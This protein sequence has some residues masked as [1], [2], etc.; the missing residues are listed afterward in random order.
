MTHKFN[1]KVYQGKVRVY[2]AVP[3]APRIS[4][5]WIWDEAAKEYKVPEQGNVYY[6]ARYE[7]DAQ[8]NKKRKYESFATLE[9]AR[10]W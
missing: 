1:V 6:A 5:L 4:R 8:G 2:T 9:V 10:N 7:N 3:K